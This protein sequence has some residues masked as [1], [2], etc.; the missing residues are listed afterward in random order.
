MG[1][2]NE[3]VPGGALP[4]KDVDGFYDLTGF[5]TPRFKF[6]IKE[7]DKQGKPTSNVLKFRLDYHA[8]GLALQQ[9]IPTALMPTGE[10]ED[11]EDPK[12]PGKTIQIPILGMTKVYK[13]LKNPKEKRPSDLPSMD[14]ILD[15]LQKAFELPEGTSIQVRLTLLGAY[16]DEMRQRLAL[17]K[18]MA[19][20]PASR[21]STPE[22][23]TSEP[24]VTTPSPA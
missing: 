12:N 24:S 11:V 1:D 22:S 16:M 3:A 17:K 9:T 18:G 2:G 7:I 13:C 19:G 23:S 4:E 21:E 5:E 15:A 10:F 14:H 20:S 6:T 8:I